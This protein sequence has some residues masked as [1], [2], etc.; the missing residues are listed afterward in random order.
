MNFKNIAIY[1]IFKEFERHWLLGT[2]H[3]NIIHFCWKFL[4]WF[5]WSLKSKYF[6]KILFC[7]NRLFLLFQTFIWLLFIYLFN[8]LNLLFFHCIYRFLTHQALRDLINY[9]NFGKKS[10]I[11]LNLS[12]FSG[13][14]AFDKKD[15]SISV[16]FKQ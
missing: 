10:I 14:S 11:F 4:K 15:F 5:V 6:I 3:S 12:I 1:I 9:I 2:I 8:F 7:F 13:T 16:F